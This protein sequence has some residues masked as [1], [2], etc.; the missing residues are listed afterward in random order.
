MKK[1]YEEPVVE[2]VRLAIIATDS[3]GGPSDPSDE[4]L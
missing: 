3:M 2:V 4:E 1:M